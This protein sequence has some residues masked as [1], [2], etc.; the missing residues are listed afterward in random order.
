MKNFLSEKMNLSHII[1]RSF[2]AKNRCENFC[3]DRKM[4][5]FRLLQSIVFNL[6]SCIPRPSAGVLAGK[7][8]STIFD[9]QGKL[10]RKFSEICCISSEVRIQYGF[11]EFPTKDVPVGSPN[12]WLS[13]EIRLLLSRNVN[14]E[15]ISPHSS[16]QSSFIRHCCVF[17]QFWQFD[18]GKFISREAKRKNIA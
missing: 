11:P 16:I 12:F 13:S 5:F 6:K 1:L 3:F 9:L 8:L 10:S 7:L 2:R 14:F 18:Q 15:K 17:H 4:V